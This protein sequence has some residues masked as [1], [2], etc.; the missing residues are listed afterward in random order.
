M[1]SSIFGS[2]TDAPGGMK[3][4]LQEVTV[5]LGAEYWYRRIF[6]LRG[7]YFNESQN[8][9]NRKYFSAGVGIKIKTCTID[10]SYLVPVQQNNPLANTIRLSV[11]FNL[12]RILKSS[13][14]QESPG[15][16]DGVK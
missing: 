5:S 13:G 14:Q 9:G 12:N 2:F 11:L 1:I 10:L 16:T 7:G 3:E 8:K 4:E 15:K 6:A